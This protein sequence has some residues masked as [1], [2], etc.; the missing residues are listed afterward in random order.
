MNLSAYKFFPL[1]NGFLAAA[2]EK[3]GIDYSWYDL[4]QN[5]LSDNAFANLIEKNGPYSVVA[6][7]GLLTSFKSVMRLCICLKS[8]FPE[9]KIV[10]GGR[11]AA[12]GPEFLLE[13][14]PVDYIVKGEGEE[15]L[16]SL[17]LNLSKNTMDEK[18]KGLWYRGKGGEVISG[19]T[20]DYIKNISDY[21][22]PYKHFDLES[23][24]RDCNIQSPNVPS[25]NMLSSRGCPFS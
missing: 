16:I 21:I 19:G 25:I 14:M 10:I 9:T 11:I 1:G 5:W 4:H 2:L 17:L 7:S 3:H 22:I 6:I 24:I 12:V 20:T 23:Y 15:A 18:I 8:R 13:Q